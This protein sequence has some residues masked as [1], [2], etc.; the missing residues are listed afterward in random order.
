MNQLINSALVLS[1]GIHNLLAWLQPQTKI[2]WASVH[3]VWNK[4]NVTSLNVPSQW[5]HEQVIKK[6]TPSGQSV[7]I[8]LLLLGKDFC[9]FSSLNPETRPA[10]FTAKKKNLKKKMCMKKTWLMN[11]CGNVSLR[12]A[13]GEAP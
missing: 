8:V 1:S 5:L 13:S 10:T 3:S 4:V 12:L 2:Y 9:L 11:I 7:N 6:Q